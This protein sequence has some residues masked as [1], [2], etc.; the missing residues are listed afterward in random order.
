VTANN[1]VERSLQRIHLQGTLKPDSSGNLASN[2]L[3]LFEPIQKPQPL[4]GKGK[5]QRLLP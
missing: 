3:A 4:L 1:L 5:R 2:T